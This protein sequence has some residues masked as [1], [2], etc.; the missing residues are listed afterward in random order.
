MN[1]VHKYSKDLVYVLITLEE[2]KQ[3][4]Q[5][6]YDRVNSIDLGEIS[7]VLKHLQGRIFMDTFEICFH[8]GSLWK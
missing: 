5:N 2:Y 1:H 4:G 3:R 7:H 6:V 8:E